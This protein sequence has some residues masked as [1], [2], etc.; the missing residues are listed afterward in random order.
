MNQYNVASAL[1]YTTK[2]NVTVLRFDISVYYLCSFVA[3]FS[4]QYACHHLSSASGSVHELV[5]L[6]FAVK[7]RWRGILDQESWHIVLSEKLCR[8][9]AS[10]CFIHC[11]SMLGEIM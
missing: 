10:T 7:K 2:I 11:N 1:H 8:P 3:S 9:Y 4:V 5:V 6:P